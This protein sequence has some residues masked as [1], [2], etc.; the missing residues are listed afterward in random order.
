VAEPVTEAIGP[1]E[2][3][4]EA[5]PVTTPAGNP[6]LA[7]LAGLADL[8]GDGLLGRGEAL[9]H[10]TA[11]VTRERLPE[12]LAWLRDQAGYQL[13]R[14]VTAVDYLRSAPR[15]HVV[16]HLLHLPAAVVA[17]EAEPQ[18]DD[19]A[20]ELRLKVSV[21]VDDPVVPSA[22]DL[23]PTA[24]FHER[25]VWDLFGIEFAGHPDLRRILLP[26]EF[27]GHP[28]RK[29]FPQRYE[30][31]AFSFNQDEVYAAKPRASE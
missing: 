6:A 15:F 18:P 25:E 17:G 12:A 14:S 7:D 11:L 16:Y 10:A 30:E 22:V 4:D 27:D 26:V 9:G 1:D 20:R 23:Y 28:L 29:D 21:G 24:N 31:V 19:P 3:A 13:L 5:A 2:A 8:L